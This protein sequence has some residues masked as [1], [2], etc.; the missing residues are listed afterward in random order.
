MDTT[1]LFGIAL[2]ARGITAGQFGQSLDPPVSDSMLWQVAAGKK[3]SPRVKTAIDKLIRQ[4]MR[5]L[6]ATPMAA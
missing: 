5:R 3:K 1:T 4:Q 2:K 6:K